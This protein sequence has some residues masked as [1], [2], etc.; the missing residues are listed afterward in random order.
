MR[1]LLARKMTYNDDSSLSFPNDV[2]RQLVV[3]IQALQAQVANGT[4]VPNRED[5]VLSHALGKKEHEV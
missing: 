1:Y 2:V 3:R 4:F 5:D